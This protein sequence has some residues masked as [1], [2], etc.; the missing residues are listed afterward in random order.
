LKVAFSAFCLLLFLFPFREVTGQFEIFVVT[1]NPY[2][3]GIVSL[4]IVAILSNVTAHGRYGFSVIDVFVILLC[5]TYFASTLL[6]K[7]IMQ[8]GLMAFHAIFIPVVSY[9]VVKSF[10]ISEQKYQ[11]ALK[12]LLAGIAFFSLLG[13]TMS[14]QSMLGIPPIGVATLAVFSICTLLFTELWKKKGGFTALVLTIMLFLTTLSRAYSVAILA[15]PILFRFIRKLNAL[16]VFSLFFVASL[17]VTLFITYNPHY[18]KPKGHDPRER[19]TINRI[20]D[21]DVWKRAMYG[22]A[23][24][25]QDGIRKFE[26]SPFFGN[27]LQRGETC[28]TIHNFHVEWLQ[29]GGFV[30]YLFYSLFFFSLYVTHNELAKKDLFSATN[31]SV[32]MV[33]LV[34]CLT[35]GI[36]HGMMPHVIFIAAGFAES[37]KKIA[38]TK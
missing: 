14:R 36:M 7:D 38:S 12:W 26:Q 24:T 3:M 23:F 18:F 4:S 2:S 22:R 27:G 34:N 29:Y 32:I 5:L 21:V 33:I 9:F 17:L 25:Y 28:V 30:G 31:L 35:N 16:G 6:S 10:V 20:L 13:L 37:R 15:S 19:G 1:V 8:T 11:A